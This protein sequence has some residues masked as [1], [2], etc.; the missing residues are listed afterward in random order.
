MSGD[1]LTVSGPSLF[2]AGQRLGDP[3]GD[4]DRQAI[5][6]LRGY[7]YQ[8]YASALAWLRLA[9]GETLYLE[10]AEDYAVAAADALQGVQVKDA[11]SSSITIR[12]VASTIDAFVDLVARNSDRQVTLRYL[13]TSTI[14]LE[15][16]RADQIEGRS[17]LKYWRRAAKGAP[18]APL[19]AVLLRLDLKPDTIIFINGLGDE[20]LR[21][22]LIRP[23]HWDAGQAPL[24]ELAAEVEA[25]LIEFA[26]GALRLNADIGRS[27]ANVTLTTVL[28][29]AVRSDQRRLR[30]ADL[31]EIGE[32]L[33]RVSLPLGVL[34][35]VLAKVGTKS[36]REEIL[37]PGEV[38]SSGPVAARKDLVKA[39]Q[40]KLAD[41][42]FAVVT[43]STGIGKTHIA[44]EAA[45][46][47]AG[48][49]RIAD[50][51][52]TTPPV[53]VSHLNA[54]L[55]EALVGSSGVILLDDL[56]F[57][58]E[59][60]V[61][62]AV[63]RLVT[64]MKRRD[65]AV[66]VTSSSAPSRRT[67][68]TICGSP[69]VAIDIPYFTIDEVADLIANAN[70]NPRLANMVHL[71]GS[72]GHPQM[73]QA[74]ILHMRSA[75]WERGAIR[76]LFDGDARDLA[77]EKRVARDRLVA[78]MPPNAR[79]LLY[80]A[81][82]ILGRF[83][84][85][86][87]LKLGDVDPTIAEPGT[88]IDR[89]VGP[90]IERPQRNE[91]R[92]SPLVADAGK[93]AL[94]PM[95]CVRVHQAVADYHL[96]LGTISV[97]VGDALLYHVLAGG[98]EHQIFAYAQSLLSAPSEIFELLA[99]Y[100]PSIA[101]L[102]TANPIFPANGQLS[103][104]LR[105]GQL[106]VVLSGDDAERAKHIWSTTKKEMRDRGEIF[107]VLLLSKILIQTI[108]V[109]AIPEWLELLLRF[110]ALTLT[111][112]KL[113]AVANETRESSGGGEPQ[114]F[115]FIIQA[116][117]LGST[118]LLRAT[119]ERLDHETPAVR[120][121]LFSGIDR[122]AGHYG[123]LV[124]AAWL[125]SAKADGF[126]S[127]QA[128]DDYLAMADLAFKWG[129]IALAARCHA[130]RAIMLEEYLKDPRRALASLADAEARL[131]PMTAISRARAKV[132]WHQRDYQNA[133][134][135][136][137]QVWAH[138][139]TDS[140][141]ME[142]GFIAR[143]AGISAAEAGDW[144][145]GRTWFI[146]ARESFAP[147][148]SGALPAIKVGLLAD[149]AQAGL[150]SGD[151]ASAVDYY[152]L[153]L[154]EL[155]GLDPDA[156][157][158]EGYC[159]RV[160]RHSVL[161]LVR[162][163]RDGEIDIELAELP[164]GA[165]SNPEPNEKIR[166]IPLA[167]IDIA[168]YL[169][170][171]A[172]IDLGQFSFFQ[173]LYAR[174]SNG[175]ILGLEVERQQKLAR[176]VVSNGESTLLAGALKSYGAGLAYLEA[177][178]IDQTVGDITNPTRASLPLYS[179][180]GSEPEPARRGAIDLFISFGI[181]RAI[182]A[183]IE[184]L[185]AVRTSVSGDEWSSIRGLAKFMVGAEGNA[186]L[187]AEYTAISIAEVVAADSFPVD[188][189]VALRA[190][191]YF[192]IWAA[193]S[194]FRNQL[195]EPLDAWTTSMWQ[196]IVDKHRFRLRNPSETAD[197]ISSALLFMGDPLARAARIAIAAHAAVPMVVPGSVR[198]VLSDLA[199]S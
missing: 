142:R 90:W 58:D 171:N 149:A 157:I 95:E 61:L 177:K 69:D 87:A 100:S 108:I 31:I 143:E 154:E 102:P 32:R 127:E 101:E 20:E 2:N 57:L 99:R 13:T 8:L 133:L 15:R 164:P 64:A 51:R 110:D 112:E 73:V 187:L 115:A 1:I 126:D 109:E 190:T 113:M 117:A 85:E 159:H 174:L 10:V 66:I 105:L 156:S 148:D 84:R 106:L 97:N 53:A 27:M 34:E 178:G 145:A 162:D 68:N 136:F 67:L 185:R 132:Y 12:S 96:G 141:G 98:A 139:G 63:R 37:F 135:G 194:D 119:L 25:G 122:S 74:A 104:M 80:R 192:T 160:V 147:Y 172:A 28:K 55:G 183:D 45:K 120:A 195:A 199:A 17:A 79:A 93:A 138:A 129:N 76:A 26:V 16:A 56:D 40:S 48:G 94:S 91:L 179:L 14:G 18:V 189:E 186:N 52:G 193:R 38:W 103:I 170:A 36:V 71:A 196:V 19:R 65:G 123:H 35:G 161:S 24:D 44:S 83:T 50:L 78:A 22:A 134:S 116:T 107:E 81:S 184:A 3:A 180:D 125:R 165:C 169:L 72:N 92:V 86:L 59:P 4:P 41:E 176:Y 23:I 118:G 131:G 54:I 114:G 82:L 75:D 9:D 175:P 62:Q 42:S 191:I 70:G 11:P 124:D 153:A 163:A 89:L 46:T 47:R 173:G 6:A 198:S 111:Q 130:A 77:E 7:I 182:T 167:P 140:D 88:E 144:E 146:R 43:G 5:S 155:S 121:R 150:K 137:E 181:L 128:A 60:R 152:A 33:G 188:P 21:N 158:H 151:S 197:H 166:E 49:W 39:L 29:T 168:W 30:R